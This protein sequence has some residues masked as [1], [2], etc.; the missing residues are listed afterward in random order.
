MNLVFDGIIYQIAPNGGISR[1]FTEIMPILCNL[2]LDLE[3]KLI[4]PRNYVG[5]IVPSNQQIQKFYRRE[6]REYYWVNIYV[7]GEY[8]KI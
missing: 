1:I 4:L 3:I 2:D 6:Y 8:G 5:V 7:H